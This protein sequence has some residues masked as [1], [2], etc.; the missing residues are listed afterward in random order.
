MGGRWE[1]AVEDRDRVGELQD[2]AMR[3]IVVADCCRTRKG[4]SGIIRRG[5]EVES[6]ATMS[7]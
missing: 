2:Q 3:R 5:K 6:G 4:R 1:R 7:L